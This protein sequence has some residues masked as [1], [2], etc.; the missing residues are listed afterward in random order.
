MDDIG[1][2]D[3]KVIIYI[4]RLHFCQVSKSRVW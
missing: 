4:G 2:S 1:N 3:L